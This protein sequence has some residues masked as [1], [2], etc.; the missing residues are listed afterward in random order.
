MMRPKSGR[1]N[2]V[3]APWIFQVITRSDECAISAAPSECS[4]H[5]LRV[6]TWNADGCLFVSTATDP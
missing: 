1:P 2:I 3:R 6:R 4:I 5:L